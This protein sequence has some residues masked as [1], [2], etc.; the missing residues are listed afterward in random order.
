MCCSPPSPQPSPDNFCP[1]PA[2]RTAIFLSTA[3][4]FPG[5]SV[6]TLSVKSR[7]LS[8]PLWLPL[9]LPH[10]PIS[11]SACPSIWHQSVGLVASSSLHPPRHHHL[12]FQLCPHH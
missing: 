10:P 8:A 7:L 4:S 6:G 12:H 1:F 9:I 11:H 3:V 2:G 5:T